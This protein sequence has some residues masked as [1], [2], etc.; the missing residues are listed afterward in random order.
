MQKSEL[1]SGQTD[2]SQKHLPGRCRGEAETDTAEN[3]ARETDS[4]QDSAQGGAAKRSAGQIAAEYVKRTLVLAVGLF[5]MS[6]GVG[7]S[8][9]A[10]LGTSPVSSIPY[11]LN[12]ITGLSVGTTTI[13][14]NVAIVLLQIVLLR[15]RFR[16]LQLLQLPVCIVF[17]LLCDLALAWMDG[18]TPD[19][20]W[21]QWL[22]C[23]AGIALVGIGVSLEVTANVTTLAGEGL[24]LAL[25]R[26]LPKVRF[27]Y[28]K[29]IVDCSFVVIA[30]ALSFLFLH[31][32]ASVREGT[33]AAALLVGLI[34]KFLNRFTVPLGKRFFQGRSRAK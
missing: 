6:F 27:G 10:D 28:M 33:V 18:V 22:I 26:L 15:R 12:L 7:L 21:Q 11:V 2:G 29:V 20:Y 32:L 5:I 9:R 3:A 31:R 23:A 25:C 1:P 24:S 4:A 19:T 34:A 8:I 13:I 14:V 17:G 16:P 30:V